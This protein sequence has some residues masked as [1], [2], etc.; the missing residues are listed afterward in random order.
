VSYA[1][2][3][4]LATD[5]VSTLPSQSQ[6]V[7]VLVGG[8]ILALV[9]HLSA[10]AWAVR[11]HREPIAQLAAANAI[12]GL[13]L[14]VAL[15]PAGIAWV[16]YSPP[17]RVLPDAGWIAH[18]PVVFAGVACTSIAVAA[19]LTGSLFAFVA[20]RHNHSERTEGIGSRRAVR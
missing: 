11:H 2:A 12:A 16:A 10:C 1:A 18:I 9:L 14:G 3:R 19:G 17:H 7:P 15:V 13:A 20:C 6:L 5:S 4:V 8:G